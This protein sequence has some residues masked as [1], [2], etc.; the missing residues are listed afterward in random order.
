VTNDQQRRLSAAAS[1]LLSRPH[2]NDEDID[3]AVALHDAL[4][5][6][7]GDPDPTAVRLR[8]RLARDLRS[9]AERSG[10]VMD[11]IRAEIFS[12][13]GWTQPTPSSAACWCFSTRA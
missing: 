12:P 10:Q 5:T 6:P 3:Q 1:A 13:A 9:R 4:L 8:Q 2:W 11:V 7:D